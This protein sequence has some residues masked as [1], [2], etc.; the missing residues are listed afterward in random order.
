MRSLTVIPGL[1]S[2]G[3][4]SSGF[5]FGP[6]TLG[7]FGI[8]IEDFGSFIRRWYSPN[9]L[10]NHM[11]DNEK[12]KQQRQQCGN[13][14]IELE[15]TIFELQKQLNA[16]G[17]VFTDL[18]VI[19][20]FLSKKFGFDFQAERAEL[21]Q[22]AAKIKREINALRSQ[23]AEFKNCLEQHYPTKCG[24]HGKETGAACEKCQFKPFYAEIAE[25]EADIA[26]RK[27][28]KAQRER[29]SAEQKKAKQAG[30]KE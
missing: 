2:Y 7:R 16:H 1:F 17:D 15:Q 23:I 19:K 8:I 6:Y 24:P 21:T 30:R 22:G 26:K 13:K 3:E 28:E 18:D 5:F 25:Q 27:Q 14:Q 20:H 29:E 4:C 10:V 11:V 12:I 9:R